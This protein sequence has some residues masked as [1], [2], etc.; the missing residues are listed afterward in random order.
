MPRVDWGI[1]ALLLTIGVNAIVSR[2]V[3][4]VARETHSAALEAEALH[5]RADL[6]SCSGVVAGL[7]LVGVTGE[8]RLDPV[9]AGVMTAAIACSALKL[10][11]ETLR[12]L[13]DERLPEE[14]EALIR[15]VLAA[16][17][18]VRDYHRLRSRRSGPHRFIDVH[19]LLD[20]AL[21]FPAAHDLAEQ[22]EA[23]IRRE[24]ENADVT[25]HPEPYERELR[26]QRE[27]H[28]PAARR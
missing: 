27:A 1:G 12:P 5:L 14:E 8:P 17:P 2:R 6:W 4:R 19:V 11:R 20:D 9:V 25:V 26:H 24:L 15:A 21:S 7:V 16:I 13:V 10:L 23:A 28:G 3:M 18:G 22:V